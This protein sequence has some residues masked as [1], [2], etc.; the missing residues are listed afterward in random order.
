MLRVD[1]IKREVEMVVKVF[2]VA[3]DIFKGI[4]DF[5]NRAHF[6]QTFTMIIKQGTHH[7]EDIARFVIFIILD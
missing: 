2:A 4:G 3:G 1:A 7:G 5:F 6:G